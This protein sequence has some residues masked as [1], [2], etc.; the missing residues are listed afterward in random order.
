MPNIQPLIPELAAKAESEL[1]EVP[2]RLE[3]DLEHI[4]T[5]LSKQ[6]HINARYG[7]FSTK[8]CN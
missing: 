2:A 6:A 7:K 4:K 1:G 3:A 5:W 8:T